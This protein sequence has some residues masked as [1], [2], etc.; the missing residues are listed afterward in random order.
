MHIDKSSSSIWEIVNI[1]I[2]CTCAVIILYPPIRAYKPFWLLLLIALPILFFAHIRK[3][4]HEGNNIS[5]KGL[6]DGVR[7]GKRLHTSLL[8]IASAAA[9]LLTPIL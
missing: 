4:K 9:L 5:L 6:Y 1:A 7:R 8:E 2:I 3:V